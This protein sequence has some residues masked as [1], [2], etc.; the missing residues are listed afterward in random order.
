MNEMEGNERGK[1]AWSEE[2]GKKEMVKTS[3]R[4]F[5]RNSGSGNETVGEGGERELD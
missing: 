4:K 5:E 2:V 1:T 3:D